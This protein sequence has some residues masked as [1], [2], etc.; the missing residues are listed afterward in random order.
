MSTLIPAKNLLGTYGTMYYVKNMQEAINWYKALGLQPSYESE[1]WTEFP[2]NGHSICLHLEDSK[3]KK[4]SG[5]IIL[6]VTNL[7]QILADLKKKNIK[8][9]EEMKEVYPGAFAADI[10]DPEGNSISLYEGP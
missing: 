10:C 4:D 5:M 7:T 2:I 3:R 6:R 9:T 8:I 1:E